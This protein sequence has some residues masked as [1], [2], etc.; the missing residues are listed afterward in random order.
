MSLSYYSHPYQP[1]TDTCLQCG[2]DENYKAHDWQCDKCGEVGTG[3]VEHKCEVKAVN[4]R[5]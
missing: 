2:M 5:H 4:K 1:P 3:L